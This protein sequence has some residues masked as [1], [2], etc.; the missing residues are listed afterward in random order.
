MAADQTPLLASQGYFSSYNVPFYPEIFNVSGQWALVDAYGPFFSW[1]NTSRARIFQRDA[2]KVADLEGMKRLL[3][4]N[5]FQHDPISTEGCGANP[6]YSA[7]NAIAARADLNP[8]N[9]VYPIPDI[10]YGEG[11][12][13]RGPL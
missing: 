5:D 2:P 7:I 10:G 9:G 6:P 1:G 4:Y 3:R 8:P 13:R 11:P 12:G